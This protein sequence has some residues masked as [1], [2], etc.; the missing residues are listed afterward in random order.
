LLAGCGAT[1]M[2]G[3]LQKY[4]FQK[5]LSIKWELTILA[6]FVFFAGF[7]AWRDEHHALKKNQATLTATQQT[8]EAQTIPKLEG[9]IHRVLAAPDHGD[10]MVTIIGSI[11]NSG[12]S[13]YADSFRIVVTTSDGKEHELIPIEAPQTAS[14]MMGS[15]PAPLMTLPA[16]YWLPDRAMMISTNGKAEGF[17]WGLAK[18]VN[19]ADVVDQKA[20]ITLYFRDAKKKEYTAI[21]KVGGVSQIVDIR[22]LQTAS[23]RKPAQRATLDLLYGDRPLEGKTLQAIDPRAALQITL[24]NLHAK[25]TGN[26]PSGQLHVRLYLSEEVDSH[27]G[28][29]ASTQSDDPHFPSEFYFEPRTHVDAGETIN[30]EPD[31]VGQPKSNIPPLEIRA[32]LKCYY[33]SQKPVEANFMLIQRVW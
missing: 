16:A 26:A 28:Q 11:T 5:P 29:W 27:F 21:G 4:V 22:H 6:G 25:N 24:P 2:L 14:E 31:F 15:G 3:L 8:L 13:S 19:P 12:A 7:Q 20:S 1:V 30:F 32:K 9:H 10:S 18:G 33:G 17:L 23:D